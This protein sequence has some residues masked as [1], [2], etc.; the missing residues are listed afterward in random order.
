MISDSTVLTTVVPAAKRNPFRCLL[1]PTHYFQGWGSLMPLQRKDW[2]Q[3]AFVLQTVQKGGPGE[4]EVL[5]WSVF[6]FLT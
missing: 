2:T 3:I 6:S 5:L 4:D 1:H